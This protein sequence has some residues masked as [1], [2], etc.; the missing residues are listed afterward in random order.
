MK[1]STDRIL[2]SHAGN[3]PRPLDLWQMLLDRDAGKDVDE[4]ALE[5]RIREAVAEAVRRQVAAGIDIVNDGEQSKRSW[6]T[7]AS[8]RLA[9]LE[10]RAGQGR[11]E[12]CG[13]D[14]RAGHGGV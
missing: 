9:G 12:D 10:Q 2:T 3:L 6:Q 4:A 7:Y 11:V 1:R 13:F 5:R 8:T 14:C